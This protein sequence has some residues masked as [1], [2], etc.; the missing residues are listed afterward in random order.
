[1]ENDLEKTKGP[2]N[3]GIVPLDDRT[4]NVILSAVASLHYGAVEVVVHH[5]RVV[6]IDKRERIRLSV[7]E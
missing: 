2:S 1:M 4:A 3:D 6:Q 5:G 7:P